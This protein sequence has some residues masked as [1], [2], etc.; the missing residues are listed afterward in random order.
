MYSLAAFS[1]LRAMVEDRHPCELDWIVSKVGFE[2]R[3]RNC[4]SIEIYRET[5][6][7]EAAALR[8]SFA[9]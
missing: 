5:S 3:R 6:P 7:F 8:R 1:N 2:P 9:I 4:G